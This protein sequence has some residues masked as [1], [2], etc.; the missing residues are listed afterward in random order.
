M[1]DMQKNKQIIRGVAVVVIVAGIFAGVS[2]SKG[3]LTFSGYVPHFSSAV[4][5]HPRPSLDRAIVFPADFSPD[6]RR[7]FTDNLA[8]LKAQLTAGEKDASAWFDLAIYYR[9]VGDNAG[10]VEIWEYVSAKYPS[11]GIALHNLGEYNFHTAKDYVKAEDYYRQSIKADPAMAANYT[12]L[13]DMY[14]YAYKQDTDS[15][16]TTLLE[17]ISKVPALSAVNF[18]VLAAQYQAEKGNIDIARTY[19]KQA[20]EVAKALKNK[21]LADQL[22]KELSRLR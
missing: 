19:Y 10:A 15:A 9:M 6:A 20:I 22:T 11:D 3:A 1:R 16:M 14:K 21:P 4:F 17:G 2:Y 12:D 5:T 18:E 7:I 8:K 13:F